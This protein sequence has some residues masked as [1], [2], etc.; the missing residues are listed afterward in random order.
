[1]KLEN[2]PDFLEI[3]KT[4][5]APPNSERPGDT[6]LEVSFQVQGFS[7]SSSCWVEDESLR[8]FHSAASDIYNHFRGGAL[9]ESMSPE[10]L[11]LSLSI[12]NPRGYVLVQVT[13]GKRF[14]ACSVS[15]SFEVPLQDVFLLAEWANSK[16]VES[17]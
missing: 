4:Y 1:M 9:L 10:E 13:L 11:H 5:I 8:E 7:G 6:R 15:G 12:A 16:S 17:M 14:P 3:V 2:K